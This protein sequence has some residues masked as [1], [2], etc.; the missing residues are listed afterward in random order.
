M[1]KFI[2]IL[3]GSSF[4]TASTFSD[5]FAEENSVSW[6]EKTRLSGNINTT[7]NYNFNNPPM[8]VGNAGRVFDVRHND[9]D[10]NRAEIEIENAPADW[11]RFRLDLAVGED[12]SIVDGLKGGV[13][14]TDEFGVQ[15]AYVALT[16]PIGNGLTF[17]MGHFATLI[18]AEVI[19]SAYNYNTSRSYL[20][21]FAIPFTHTGLY[22]TYP[23][24]DVFSASLGVVNGW[25][26]IT[27]NNKAKTILWQFAFDPSE[28]LSFSLQGTMGP[29]ADA[30]VGVNGNDSDWLAL[31]DFVLNWQPIEKFTLQLNFDWA[32]QQDFGSKSTDWWGAA[33]LAHYDFN[34]LFGLTVRG[35]MFDDNAGFRF[36]GG[37]DHNL[38]EGTFTGHFYLT[39]GFEAR[40]EFRHDQSD[41][42]FFAKSDGTLRKFQDTVS[43]ELLYK[44]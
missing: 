36:G 21:G 6:W 8:G 1:R 10:I 37:T 35:E 23:F 16:A 13:I 32:N 19:E 42:D 11:A 27:D 26:T 40:L 12:I 22:A 24:N 2:L 9:F 34:D 38:Y 43:A 20:F 41:R 30:S 18:G 7:Y 33:L 28:T 14:G 4:L 31:V 39:E 25:D 5:V 15:Q 3:I 29:D 44:F 17:T